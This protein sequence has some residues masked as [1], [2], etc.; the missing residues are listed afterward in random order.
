M[1]LHYCLYYYSSTFGSSC[2]DY[3]QYHTTKEQAIQFLTEDLADAES[4]VNIRFPGIKQ[5]RFDALVD[6]VF[7]LGTSKFNTSTLYR[8]IKQNP[9]D[10]TIR[11]EFNRWI[12]SNGKVLPGLVTRR[13]WEANLYFS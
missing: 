6:F 13:V 11:A 9:D 8:K 7:N 3:C 2:C 4:T 1:M 10:P 5:N 12:Y